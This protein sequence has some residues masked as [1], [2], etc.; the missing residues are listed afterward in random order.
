MKKPLLHVLSPCWLTF[1]CPKMFVKMSFCRG[2]SDAAVMWLPLTHTEARFLS[3][4]C[5]VGP[6]EVQ[7][8]ECPF[9][10]NLCWLTSLTFF[11]PSCGLL[12][13][14]RRVVARVHDG[15]TRFS[16]PVLED[17]LPCTQLVFRCISC[18]SCMYPGTCRR[19]C[20]VDKEGLELS[21]SMTSTP[22][23]KTLCRC[24]IRKEEHV[25]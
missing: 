13:A 15:A 11:A 16:K 25:V 10:T 9:Q 21:C 18:G 7:S 5:S 20:C 8:S 23:K 24:L 19:P 12:G 2:H 1:P 17:Q 4:F 3:G 6:R 14:S 22:V